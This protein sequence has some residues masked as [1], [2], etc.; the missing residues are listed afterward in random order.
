MKIININT[1]EIYTQYKNVIKYNIKKKNLIS[2]GKTPATPLSCPLSLEHGDQAAPGPV[3]HYGL[4]MP[5]HTPHPSFVVVRGTTRG[6]HKLL[7]YWLAPTSSK[8]ALVICHRKQP[9]KMR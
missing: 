2:S 4:S 9:I 8:H 7:Q 1:Y 6:W 5:M 3:S